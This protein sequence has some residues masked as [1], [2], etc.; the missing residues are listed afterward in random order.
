MNKIQGQHICAV[1]NFRSLTPL[2]VRLLASCS[3]I[4]LCFLTLQQVE[5]GVLVLQSASVSDLKPSRNEKNC[6]A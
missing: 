4:P 3:T 2:G 5:M 1:L 6:K